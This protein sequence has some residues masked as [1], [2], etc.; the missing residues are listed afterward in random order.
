MPSNPSGQKDR[1]S[2]GSPAVLKGGKE[3]CS[4]VAKAKALELLTLCGC[5]LFSHPSP[6]IWTE[7]VSQ[8]LK[9]LP[10]PCFFF[11]PFVK[12]NASSVTKQISI[13]IL[14]PTYTPIPCFNPSNIPFGLV[15][16][17]GETFQIVALDQVRS[18]IR[19][20]LQKLLEALTCLLILCA[21]SDFFERGLASKYQSAD[22]P[23]HWLHTIY[24]FYPLSS[25]SV[26]SSLSHAP[27]QTT[28]R[29]ACTQL[30]RPIVSFVSLYGETDVRH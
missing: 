5:G 21:F 27:A 19:E 13:P 29:P 24:S 7:V 18:H 9:M 23:L 28:C 26:P 30:L 20:D 14:P 15:V 2:S 8:F 25:Y 3:R 16:G 17:S 10:A 6:A 12:N 4:L 22:L 11:P 1:L